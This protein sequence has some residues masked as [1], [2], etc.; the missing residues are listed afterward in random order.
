V[1]TVP[2]VIDALLAG[3]RARPAL[4]DLVF[5][6]G[7]PVENFAGRRMLTI[8]GQDDPT[9]E[10]TSEPVASPNRYS[11]DYSLRLY[12]SSSSGM[13]T[14]RAATEAAFAIKAEVHA[15][16]SADP[17]LGFL[18]GQG[19]LV[20]GG[21]L[22]QQWHPGLTTTDPFWAEVAFDVRVRARV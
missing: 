14:Q 4:A 13:D 21:W 3:L 11:E 15:F 9:A 5:G 19:A 16:L 17:S 1:T 10:G 8:G 20:A 12:A 18:V 2:A 7:V 22:L 6:Y